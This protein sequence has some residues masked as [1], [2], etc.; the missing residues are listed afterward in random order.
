MRPCSG[1]NLQAG[2][3]IQPG[4]AAEPYPRRRTGIAVRKQ[5]HPVGRSI[6]SKE[7][8]SILRKLV[9]IQ[10]QADRIGIAANQSVR[11]T[12]AGAAL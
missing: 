6:R 11:Q 3:G 4:I 12:Y 9:R 10:P 1:F 5:T 2:I 7:G 8:W